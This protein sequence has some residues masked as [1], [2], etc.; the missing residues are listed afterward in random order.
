MVSIIYPLSSLLGSLITDLSSTMTFMSRKDPNPEP[1]ITPKQI[2][3]IKIRYI[4]KSKVI[5][6]G[7]TDRNHV[8]FL[9]QI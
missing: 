3:A 9:S 4:L 6:G 7:A 2:S 5:E 8:T 1:I